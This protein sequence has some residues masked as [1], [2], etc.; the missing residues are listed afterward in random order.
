MHCTTR[1]WLKRAAFFYFS[2]NI[3][4]LG[5]FTIYTMLC[6][7]MLNSKFPDS[8]IEISFYFIFTAILFFLD[9]YLVHWPS[10]LFLVYKLY[11]INSKWLISTTARYIKKLVRTSIIAAYK[12]TMITQDD[13]WFFSRLF[14]KGT[15]CPWFVNTAILQNI[16]FLNS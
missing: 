9:K 4:T 11:R 5:M 16:Y 10:T 15:F 1:I 13:I 8:C 3:F 2:K 7:K 12:K 6:Y 14:W